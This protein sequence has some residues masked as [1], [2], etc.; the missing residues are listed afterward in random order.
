ME[1]SLQKTDF[2]AQKSVAL[3]KPPIVVGTALFS[4]AAFIT[5]VWA[6]TSKIPEKVTG[7]G[8]LQPVESVFRVKANGEGFLLYPFYEKAGKVRYGIPEWSDE[9]FDFV[10]DPTKLADDKLFVLASAILRD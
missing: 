1:S 3:L 2:A 5:G 10:R 9:A 4:A 7:L 8:I 6:F